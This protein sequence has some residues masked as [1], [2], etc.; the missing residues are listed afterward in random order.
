MLSEGLGQV[1]SVLLMLSFAAYVSTTDFESIAAGGKSP[2]ATGDGMR[3]NSSS[4]HDG[5]EV[6]EH[7]GVVEASK[8]GAYGEYGLEAVTSTALDPPAKCTHMEVR[9]GCFIV[10]LASM[11]TQEISTSICTGA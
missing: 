1:I 8:M 3:T 11:D 6:P 10:S 4:P 5:P 2:N 9:N 7:A